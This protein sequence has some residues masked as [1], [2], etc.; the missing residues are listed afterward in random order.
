MPPISQ[1]ESETQIVITLGAK[2]T[3]SVIWLHGLGADGNDFA[4]IVPQL[5][6]PPQMSIRFIFPH[7]PIQAVTINGGMEM[8]SWYDILTMEFTDRED[9]VGLEQARSLVTS[10]I[11]QQ[12]QQGIASSNILL[13]GFSQ[14]GAVAL[15]TV[16]RHPEA[17][18][19][20]LALS[21]YLP[22]P[23]KLEDAKHKSNQNT[24]ILM[25]H[26][27]YDPIIP[28]A[29]AKQSKQHLDHLGYSVQWHAF[30]MEHSVSTE[31]IE[32][33]S[34]FISDVLNTN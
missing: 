1:Q 31:E 20:V 33:I 27:E 2:P 13:A 18:G 32:V 12:N 11:T 23:D 4:G 3:N 14:G 5:S 25:A 24:S 22:F 19:A 28:I 16:L 10:I 34:K 21:T 15:H 8:R 30:P 6:L 29:L 26:G 17:L 9:E 7:A